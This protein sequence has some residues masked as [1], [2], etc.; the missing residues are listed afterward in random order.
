MQTIDMDNILSF[1]ESV[2]ETKNRQFQLML[3]PAIKK[4]QKYNPEE[5]CRKSGV[6]YDSDKREILIRTMN[7]EVRFSWPEFELLG[8]PNR[9]LDMWHHL[10]LLQYMD[11]GDGTPLSGTA[12]GL[13]QMRGGL[14]RAKGYERHIDTMCLYNLKTVEKDA[15]QKA[16]SEL[17]AQIVKSRAD[18]TAI[19]SFAPFFPITINFWEADEEYPVSIK[20]LVDQAAE[21]Y[22][23]IE[24]A[25]GAC[26]IVM[27][28]VARLL[29]RKEKDR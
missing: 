6:T 15:F 1:Q 16:C 8:D 10:T 24:A 14:A 26:L 23:G 7:Q 19:I 29:Q 17:G 5:L 22:L 20:V 2:D 25:G 9:S 3:E 21:H 28:E 12:M 11:T 27:E 13:A 4:L 18:V